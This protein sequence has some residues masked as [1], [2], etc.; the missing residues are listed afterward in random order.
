MFKLVSDP[1]DSFEIEHKNMV[2]AFLQQK[3]I[4]AYSFYDDIYNDQ[5]NWAEF[6]ILEETI[7][8]TSQLQKIIVFV[9]ANRGSE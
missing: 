6:Q 3:E 5:L 9:G 1:Q 2:F 7:V 8:S 4:Y